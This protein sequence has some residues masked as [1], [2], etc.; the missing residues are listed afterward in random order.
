MSSNSAH[1][2]AASF[3]LPMQMGAAILTDSILA[4]HANARQAAQIRAQTARI[5]ARRQAVAMAAAREAE[6][7]ETEA[8]HREILHRRMIARRVRV[9]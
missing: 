3:E 2:I 7:R 1:R 5:L 8:Q 9:A 6:A 4:A